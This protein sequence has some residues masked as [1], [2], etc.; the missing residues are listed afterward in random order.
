MEKDTINLSLK[1]YNELRDFKTAIENDGG[2]KFYWTSSGYSNIIYTKNQALEKLADAN[3]LL[4]KR[5]KDLENPK[6]HQPTYNEIKKMNWW[7]FRKF[8]RQN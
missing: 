8:K 3:I 4:A 5:I 7:Q 1:D 6:T 2:V